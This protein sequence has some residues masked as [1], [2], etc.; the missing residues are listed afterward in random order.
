MT[1]ALMLLT[2]SSD[3]TVP[4]YGS[5]FIDRICC[6]GQL[7]RRFV[8]DPNRRWSAVFY[9]Y[10]PFRD[11]RRGFCA[12]GVATRLINSPLFVCLFVCWFFR[13][14][15]APAVRE[16]LRRC[17]HPLRASIRKSTLRS[18]PDDFSFI[19]IFKWR[20]AGWAHRVSIRVKWSPRTY[21]STEFYVFALIDFGWT[22]SHVS[23]RFL[24]NRYLVLPSFF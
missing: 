4:H 15:L 14:V 20:V 24:R 18:D 1:A 9:R 17:R 19:L 3:E 10:R 5:S 23:T 22:F 8:R 21:S 12:S 11:H 7:G 6:S 2:V 16:D 13:S